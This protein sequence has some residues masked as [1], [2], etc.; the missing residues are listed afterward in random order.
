MRLFR[1]T[2]L[3][4][5]IALSLHNLHAQITEKP[6]FGKFAIT[7]ATVHTVT[8]GVIENGTVLIDGH[9]ISYVGTDADY[10]NSYM[11]INAEGKHVYPGLMDSQTSL[12][13]VEIGAVDRTVDNREVGLMNPHVLA[14]TAINPHSASIPVTRVNGV[15][16]V[17]SLPTGSGIAGKA[18][19]IDLWGYSPDSMAVLPEAGLHVAWPSSGRRGWWDSRS[20]KEIKEEYD[21][22]IEMLNEYWAKAKFYDQMMTEFEANAD[23][24]E[25]PDKDLRMEAMRNV[26]NGEIPIIISVNGEKDILNALEWIKEVEDARFILN[27]VR[28]GWRVAEEIA[29]AGIPVITTT[30]Y[31]PTRSYDN[32]QRPYQNPGMMAKAGVKVLLASGDTENV[33]NLPYNAGY[34]ATYGM[35]TEE[36]LKAVTINPAEAFG[37]ADKLGS[38]EAGKHANLI[39]T[40]GDPFEPLTNFEQVFIRGLKIPMVSRHT[41]LFEEFLN[42][43][44]VNK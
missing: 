9:L 36:A 11:V 41:Q 18:T 29:E 21:K 24:K 31:T 14:F 27:G 37:V 43:D 5:I 6:E 3:T 42:R 25:H 19:L 38:L 4:A 16:H 44:A 12:G 33:R 26:V 15:T 23:G 34:A 39:I 1:I 20:E 30:L 2:L 28:E 10:D 8:N 35:G 22:T 13:L 40:D 32:Y 17:I 7:N